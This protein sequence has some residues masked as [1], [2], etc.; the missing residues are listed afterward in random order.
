MTGI[1]GE[2]RMLT[3]AT[4]ADLISADNDKRRAALAVDYSALGEKLA[5]SGIDI[6]RIKAKAAAF[7]VAIP[8]WGVGTGGTRF[9]RFPGKGEPRNVFEKLEDCAVIHSLTGATPTVSL[10]LPWDHTDD[11]PALR[12]RGAA[13]GL[14]FDAVNSNTFQD[15][16]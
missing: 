9:A 16:P 5:R 7:G 13:L 11:M 15:R 10:H 12:Q 4:E 14:G 2:E 8:S 6:D 1:G 3:K